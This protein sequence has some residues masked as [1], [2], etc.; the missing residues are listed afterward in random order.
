MLDLILSI[1]FVVG[2]A[3]G[4]IR[5]IELCAQR[6]GSPNTWLIFLVGVPMLMGAIVGY[7]KRADM[8]WWQMALS[9]VVSPAIVAVVLLVGYAAA[10]PFDL[11]ALMGSGLRRLC[12]RV[13]SGRPR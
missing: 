8:A 9:P 7:L 10:N 6:L 12:T 5:L 2:L 13:F 1:A 11:L 4:I 3:A